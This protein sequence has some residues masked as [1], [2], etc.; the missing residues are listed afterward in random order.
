MFLFC[1]GISAVYAQDGEFHLDK[2][3]KLNKNGTIDLGSSD[4]RVFVTGSLRADA[5][6]KI[7]RKV[8]V[9]GINSSRD[10]FRV[11]VETVNGDLRI[12]EHENSFHSGFITY[13]KE[14]Y[15]IE[16]EAPEGVSLTIRGDDGDY[17][18]KNIN[19]DISMSLDDAD[20]ELS[21]CK[22]GSFSFRL[23]DGDIRMDQ[24]RG[25]LEIQADDGDVEIYNG[26]FS[27]IRAKSDDGDLIIET[28][29]TDNGEYFFDSQDGTI[30]VNITGGGGDFD[31]RHDD[32]SVTAQ[33]DFKTQHENEDHTKLSLSGGSAKVN[34]RADDARVKLT[35]ASEKN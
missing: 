15:R 19:G 8:V 26:Q 14:D 22:G 20:A 1:L 29:L 25:S 16:I 3:Y 11:E 13:T 23:D 32:A 35:Q 7:D 17:Y 33:G 34:V 4:A 9:K 27:S 10:E 31:I 18:I 5:H 12:R 24:G 21:G 28:S 30:V 6:V 2:V